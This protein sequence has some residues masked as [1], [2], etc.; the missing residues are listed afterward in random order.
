MYGPLFVSDSRPVGPPGQHGLPG[1]PG[2]AGDKGT[3]GTIGPPGLTGESF[4]NPQQS[5]YHHYGNGYHD[6]NN[7]HDKKD[8]NHNYPSN[9]DDSGGPHDQRDEHHNL[10]RQGSGHYKIKMSNY[11]TMHHTAYTSPRPMLTWGSNNKDRF[12]YETGN[13]H[14]RSS[15][16]PSYPIE[17]RQA[18]IHSDMLRPYGHIQEQRQ[19]YAEQPDSRQRPEQS[20]QINRYWSNDLESFIKHWPEKSLIN[21]HWPDEPQQVNRHWPEQPQQVNRHWPEQPQQVNGHWPEQPQQ[22]NK[23]WPEQPQQIS[24]H[25][26]DQPQQVNRHWREQPHTIHR[27]GA[28]TESKEFHEEPYHPSYGRAQFHEIEQRSKRDDGK[29]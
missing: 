6:D 18:V 25:W 12:N 14:V 23:H 26:L 3:K 24:R 2:R 10:N 1:P 4:E 8:N 29:Y 20:Q 19:G 7:N 28:P 13:Q 5:D 21:R 22:V 15:Q 27:N 9:Y 17:S 16:T 11:R